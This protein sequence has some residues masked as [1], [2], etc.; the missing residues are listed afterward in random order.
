MVEQNTSNVQ[1]NYS[2]SAVASF[3]LAIL[4]YPLLLFNFYRSGGDVIS[5]GLWI[6]IRI[7]LLLP[8]IST[9]LAIVG[10]INIKRE[11]L[12][13]KALAILG[14]VLPVVTFLLLILGAINGIVGLGIRGPV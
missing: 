14:I 6:L 9:I 1:Q 2:K 13:G 3:I 4:Y 11:G 8:V 10:L 5:F 12:K 7:I